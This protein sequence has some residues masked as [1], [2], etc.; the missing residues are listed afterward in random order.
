ME[1]KSSILIDGDKKT[2]WNAITDAHKLSQW[3][4]P[5]SPW[6]ITKLSVGE[7]GTFTLMP[8]RHNNL[9]EMLPMTFTIKL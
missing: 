1:D 8:S 2:I 4:V 7:K 9:S 3:Y 6:K 5:G